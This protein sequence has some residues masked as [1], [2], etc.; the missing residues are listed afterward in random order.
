ML[1]QKGIQINTKWD[2]CA[3]ICEDDERWNLLKI[4]DKKR[5]FN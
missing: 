1:K 3:K 4:S 2:S 5:Y